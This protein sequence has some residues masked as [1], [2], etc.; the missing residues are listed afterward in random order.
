LGDEV[1][2]TVLAP[3][4]GRLAALEERL[5]PS[6]PQ[7]RLVTVL[8]A[9]IACSTQLSQGLEPEEVLDIMDGALRR[10]ATPIDEHGGHVTRFMG[11]GFL[12]IFG[13]PVTHEN[14]ARQAVRAGLAILQVA[15]IYAGELEQERRID[16]FGVR[17]G[18]ST[19]TVAAGGFSE[20]RDTV[21][22]LTVNLAARL[23]VAAS[24]DELLISHATY[25][26]V[27]GFFEIERHEP[28][29]ADGFPEPVTVYRVKHAWP[30]TFRTF[31]R[32]VEGVE[33]P[34]VGREAEMAQLHAA[35]ETTVHQA[36]THLITIVGD[37]GIGKSRLLYEFDAWLA[38]RS[39]QVTA[40]K[41]RASE[42]A[43]GA[44]YG[45]LRELFAYRFQIL[46]SDPA[47]VARGRLEAK[48]APT[49]ADQPQMKAALVG[50]LLGYDFGDSPHVRELEHDSRQL[51]DRALLYM[52]EFF[53]A[54]ADA[55]PTV[56]LLDDMQWADGPS[57]DAL[58][59]I[60]RRCPRLHLLVIGLARP[61]LFERHP[62]WGG[63]EATGEARSSRLV[64]SPLTRQASQQLVT[65]IL[66]RLETQ[67]DP[68]RE[69]LLSA[70]EGNPFY[71]EELI[72]VMI[73]DGVIQKDAAADAWRLDLERSRNLRLPPT[74]MAVLQARL[75]S[76]PP[77]EKVVLQQAAVLGRTFWSAALQAIRGQGQPPT[78]ELKALADRELILRQGNSAF[79]Q[80]DEYAFRQ[81][82]MREAAYDTIPTRLR[83]LYHA[84]AA[85][86]LVQA[87]K[88]RSRVD[89]YSAVIAGHYEQAHELSAAVDWYLRAG[90]Q[91]SAQGAPVEAY[92]SFDRALALLPTTDLER[93]RRA[94]LGR[95]EARETLG[96]VDECMLERSVV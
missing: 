39:E 10:L 47:T 58:V 92:R 6:E 16:G 14:D 65:E 80:G 72:Q 3:L 85:T 7:R 23:Q 66:G 59:E 30:R 21:M 17:V 43:T 69:Q 81:V 38:A 75:D 41:A 87:T 67:A 13:L 11:D 50:A 62:H 15:G 94:L 40:F 5:E 37:T 29:R 31:S 63:T 74:L 45:L 35:Y 70:A 32:G 19:G 36:Q 90:R 96:R 91:A 54:V 56:V 73:D 55:L 71:I 77:A 42:Q 57:L 86:W 12:A 76:L 93:R 4:Q 82:L 79:G 89:E 46:N 83:R 28:V 78:A 51:R 48:L 1:V 61:T 44:P 95:D 52:S 84:R 22:G 34:L 88:A 24:P 68:F 2:H 8:F 20:A 27:R 25:Q 9:D 53:S 18:I 60:L 64:L 33:T 49:F 26:H